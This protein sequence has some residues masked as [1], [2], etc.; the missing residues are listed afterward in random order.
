MTVDQSQTPRG[1]A[2][3]KAG[4]EGSNGNAQDH[5]D[6][7]GGSGSVAYET[8][9]KL[10][11][12][13]KRR[14]EELAAA[15]AKIEAFQA[16]MKAREEAELR[17]KEDYKRLLE[18]REKELLET[19]AKNES[20]QRMVEEATKIQALQKALNGA[21]DP[22]FRPLVDIDQIVLDPATGK[23]DELSVTAYAEKFRQTYPTVLVGTKMAPGMPTNAPQGGGG[24]LTYEAWLKLPRDEMIKRQKDVEGFR[25]G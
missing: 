6:S 12:E 8:H 25:K 16:D 4:G 11:A 19:K 3:P 14:D 20:F 13:K 7:G 9:R 10:L 5:G 1:S 23:V 17:Q 18:L 22:K 2:D 15:N 24:S 21:L